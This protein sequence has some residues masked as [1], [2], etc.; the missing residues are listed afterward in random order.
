MQNKQ[1][2][3]SYKVY[4]SIDELPAEWLS[5]LQKAIEATERSYAPFSNFNVGAAILLDN[6][7]VVCGSNQENAAFP[8]GLCA[9]RSACYYAGATWPGAKMLAIAIAAK[10]D[11]K[12]TA[13]PTYPCGACRQALVQYESKGG[14]PMK[15]IVGSAGRVEVFSSV[16]DLLPFVFDNLEDKPGK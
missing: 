9:E 1:L 7:Q 12:L 15:V 3:I 13:T 5:L 2:N 6:G 10:Q 11:G 14:V 8:S 4:Q 16:K